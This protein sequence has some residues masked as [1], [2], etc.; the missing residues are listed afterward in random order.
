[1]G[2]LISL[3]VLPVAS[4]SNQ[5]AICS[6]QCQA[7]CCQYI[8]VKI[9][10]P[11]TKADHEEIRWWVAHQGISVHVAQR[12]WY[13]QVLTPCSYLMPDHLCGAYEKRPEVCRDY[14]PTNCEFTAEPDIEWEF[15]SMEAYDRYLEE[16]RQQRRAA[17]QSCRGNGHGRT[18]RS[19][20]Q[21]T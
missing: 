16:K 12:K 21:S 2:G 18:N 13:L 14:D 7:R 6:Q 19:R 8:I 9:P 3:P 20:R 10:A 1:M 11:R 5:A 4:L 15:T 17:H